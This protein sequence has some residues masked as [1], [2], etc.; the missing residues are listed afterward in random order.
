MI[1]IVDLDSLLLQHSKIS[2]Q[3]NIVATYFDFFNH[4]FV[5]YPSKKGEIQFVFILQKI[6]HVDLLCKFILEKYSTYNIRFVIVENRDNL[7]VCNYFYHLVKYYEYEEGD[8]NTMCQIISNSQDTPFKKY[9]DSNLMIN[10]LKMFGNRLQ[11]TRKNFTVNEF[12][13]SQI[14]KITISYDSFYLT[15]VV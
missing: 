12:I 1:L 5:K 7:F 6:G 14:N 4:F 8:N 11:T 2:K 10:V 13:L 3:K 9:H 15:S